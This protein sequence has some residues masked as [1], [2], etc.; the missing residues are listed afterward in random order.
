VNGTSKKL[1]LILR[2]TPYGNPLSRASLDVALAAA[3]FDQ[4]ITLLF[5]DDGVWQLLPAQHPAGLQAKNL[6]STLASMPLYDIEIFHVDAQ[7]L[8]QRQL[9]PAQLQG[10][11]NVVSNE[12]LAGFIDGFD[13]VLG[14]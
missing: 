2:C 14:F 13:Q 7:S 6:Q 4:D 12:D 11:I 1:L 3:V 8:A 5:M 9:D 10:S